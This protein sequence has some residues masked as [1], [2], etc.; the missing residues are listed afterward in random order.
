MVKKANYL[1]FVSLFAIFLMVNNVVIANNGDKKVVRLQPCKSFYSQ[2]DVTQK[3]RANVE[4]IVRYDYDL[5]GETI[6]MPQ[7]CTLNFKGGCIRNGEII[8]DNTTIKGN[9]QIIKNVSL[10]GTINN[11]KVDLTW[12]SPDSRIAPLLSW[13]MSNESVRVIIIPEGNYIIDEPVLLRSNILITGINQTATLIADRSYLEKYPNK[14]VMLSTVKQKYPIQGTKVYQYVN[15][16]DYNQKFHDIT[17]SNL[18]FDLNYHGGNNECA[19]MTA[20]KIEDARDV[21]IENCKFIDR[22][23]ESLNHTYHAVY[24]VKSKH[25]EVR[26]CYTE[27]ISFVKI[28][29][30]TDIICANNVGYNSIGTW[31]ESIDGRGII[32]RDNVLN[33]VVSMTSAISFNSRYSS[34]INNK[35]K[36]NN[37]IVCGIVL[38]HIS[39]EQLDKSADSC[40]VESNLFEILGDGQYDYGVYVQ[41]GQN[42]RIKDNVVTSSGNTI[43][44]DR[45]CQAYI[46]NNDLIHTNVANSNL[47]F[48]TAKEI[49][50]TNNKITDTGKGYPADYNIVVYLRGNVIMS[51]NFFCTEA[52]GSKYNVI[53]A[54][55]GSNVNKLIIEDNTFKRISIMGHVLSLCV[56]RNTFEDLSGH[57]FTNSVKS[58][59]I[60]QKVLI[61][62]NMIK[63]AEKKNGYL[64]FLSGYTDKQ[65]NPDT[66]IQII[67]NEVNV[68]NNDLIHLN[69][70][71]G[72]IKEVRPQICGKKGKQ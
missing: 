1:I 29:G 49:K 10:F 58:D 5:N 62:N 66:D 61:K 2:I 16:D 54:A 31:L 21:I 56:E 43:R 6:T 13:L 19:Q 41:N 45:E 42:I 36:T 25:C 38:G 27:N 69:L 8:F 55:P 7:G 63:W 40:I 32:Y 3:G 28:I 4:Y 11:D 44:I 70:N 71:D 46:E 37:K 9:N 30:C 18:T 34:A 39:S 15:L 26:R 47:Y 17:I 64:L 72:K 51:R 53:W 50:L 67:D 12:F 24:F 33:E 35:V 65:F 20:I 57:L 68:Q 59:G 48:N 60:T 22:C 14:F 52:I 23:T